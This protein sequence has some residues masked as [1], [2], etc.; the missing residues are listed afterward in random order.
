[1]PWFF[2]T[3][4]LMCLLACVFILLPAF[5]ARARRIDRNRLNVQLFQ[6]RLAELQLEQ[7]HALISEEQA[8][9]AIMELE[10]A[11]LV[12]VSD[13]SVVHKPV[14]PK[15]NEALLLVVI[16]VLGLPAMSF[17]LYHVRGFQQETADWLRLQEAINPALD[18]FSQGKGLPDSLAKQPLEAVVHV[19]Q[20][21]LQQQEE[22][23]QGWLL[24][25]LLYGQTNQNE[26]SSQA[27]ERALQLDPER[28]EI[29][30]AYA[31]TLLRQQNGQLSKRSAELMQEVLQ[32]DPG[33]S[34]ALTFLA[35]ASYN[36]GF[37]EQALVLWKQLLSLRQSQGDTE[38]TVMIEKSIAMAEAALLQQKQEKQPSQAAS[39]DALASQL[40]QL[41][42]A[43][44]AEGKLNPEI[45][46]L[47]KS[48]FAQDPDN[49]QALT[50]LAM[51]AFNSGQYQR[52]IDSWEQL[53]KQREPESEGAQLIKSSI[54]KAKARL[55]AP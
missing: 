55:S 47:L 1:M 29:K 28:V 19:L 6:E 30:I 12:D 26:N 3:A 23:P 34:R 27:F 38:K 54:E 14:V 51:A 4:A 13:Q 9:I 44:I 42:Q 21:R 8:R 11:L 46:D 17:G 45:E 48:I 33:N 15:A 50:F 43:V 10:R 40:N 53:L 20:A 18:E 22:S 49:A 37:Y 41:R 16:V 5:R 31:E 52:A 2:I 35:M 7:R 25:G 39:S 32:A 24:L 36:S